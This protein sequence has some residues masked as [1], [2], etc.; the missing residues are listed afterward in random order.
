VSLGL[1]LAEALRARRTSG[2]GLLR[3]FCQATY[4]R[5]S[6]CAL[7]PWEYY[8]FGVYRDR[9]PMAEKRRFIGWR[10]EI[11]IDRAANAPDAR[12]PAN[13]KLA[14]HALMS[15]LGAP[16]PRLA[17]VYGGSATTPV[18]ATRLTDSGHVARFLHDPTHYPLFVKP[19]RGARGRATTAI[20]ELNPDGTELIMTSGERIELDV[21]IARLER[22]RHGMLF[23][24]LLRS[25]TETAAISG[26]RLTST[27]IIVM[28][29]PHGPELLSAVWRIPTGHNMT[30]NFDVGHTGNL[31]AHIDPDSGRIGRVVQ[32]VGWEIRPVDRHPDTGASFDG[33]TLADWIPARQLCLDLAP[34]LPGLRLQ[35]WDIALTD[36][37]PVIIEVNVEG[38]LRTH[39]VVQQRGIFGTRMRDGLAV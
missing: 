36:R 29:T 4:L 38:G 14:F 28:L 33:L 13:D 24:E 8:F 35:H 1:L 16:V 26:A 5:Y 10:R 39:Q 2:V 21:F 11:R 22:R 30:D 9:Y 23:Q 27:R 19:V 12:T 7:D 6:N 17:A 25:H 37:G 15:S 32:G 18:D 31:V 20:E 3:Q 34:Q